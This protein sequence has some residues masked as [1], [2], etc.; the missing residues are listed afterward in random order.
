MTHI[1]R[2][3]FLDFIILI[4]FLHFKCIFEQLNHITLM[5]KIYFYFEVPESKETRQDNP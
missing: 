5:I 3:P 2:D 4:L 1:N